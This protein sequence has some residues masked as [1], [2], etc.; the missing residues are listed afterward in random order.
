MSPFSACIQLYLRLVENYLFLR[1]FHSSLDQGEIRSTENAYETSSNCN[2]CN[3]LVTRNSVKAL[4]NDLFLIVPTIFQR[5]TAQCEELHTIHFFCQNC[6]QLSFPNISKFWLKPPRNHAC[7]ARI[8]YAF[9][10]DCECNPSFIAF[11][12]VSTCCLDNHNV[13][14][15]TI[16]LRIK[17]LAILIIVR[18]AT[19]SYNFI[20]P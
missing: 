17:Q 11:E 6:T 19:N 12:N 16:V 10:I 18:I 9:S 4:C 14:L 2:R 1:S 13:F 15:L 8:V 7:E 3:R 5:V 20:I